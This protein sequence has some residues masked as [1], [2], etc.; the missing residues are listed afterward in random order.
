M[1][2]VGGYASDDGKPLREMVGLGRVE[3]PTK[4]LGTACSI[5]LSYSPRDNR[6]LRFYYTRP[7]TF[8]LHSTVHWNLPT[9]ICSPNM[10]YFNQLLGPKIWGLL[11]VRSLGIGRL[12]LNVYVFSAFSLVDFVLF[13]AWS[14]A[15]H[16]TDLAT[17]KLRD[18][19]YLRAGDPSHS[20]IGSDKPCSQHLSESTTRMIRALAANTK[21][22][23]RRITSF[24][25][26]FIIYLA[27]SRARAS[28]LCF[29]P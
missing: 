29:R 7:T 15:E 28:L 2:T 20:A 23:A 13:W 26:P 25:P 5:H 18:V 1:S 17:S 11:R 10:L 4:R 21:P 8:L 14:G 6:L 27:A 24:R 22:A 16:A 3:L 9:H 12:F 19:P